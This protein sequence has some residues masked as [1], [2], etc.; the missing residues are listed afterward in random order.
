MSTPTT[1]PEQTEY[2]RLETARAIYFAWI[3]LAATTLR[4]TLIRHGHEPVTLELQCAPSSGTIT[5]PHG[6]CVLHAYGNAMTVSGTLQRPTETSS[7]LYTR[8]PNLTTPA[9]LTTAIRQWLASD[10]PQRS[11]R[12]GGSQP[13]Y[14]PHQDPRQREHA[15]TAATLTFLTSINALR[16]SA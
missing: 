10:L 8:S 5:T 9:Q 15:T 16:R 1:R 14:R 6:T 13:D 7:V 4:D 11:R 3:T 2:A 12:R